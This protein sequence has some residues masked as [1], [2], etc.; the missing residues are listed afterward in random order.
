M[1]HIIFC[2]LFLSGCYLANG[3]PSSSNYW[4]KDG[5]SISYKDASECYAKS[6]ARA[7]SVD[8]EKSRFSY[9]ERKFNDNPIDMIN[10]HKDDYFEYVM[11]SKSIS[12]LNKEC[13]YHLGYRFQAPLYWCVAESNMK[14]CRE[15]QKYRY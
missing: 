6:Q 11:L 15:N 1:K 9:L 2:S 13:F 4:I 8:A 7:L 14:T 5:K 3:S 12:K 10:N